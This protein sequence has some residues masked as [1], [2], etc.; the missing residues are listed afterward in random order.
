M[1]IFNSLIIHN[2]MQTDI[3]YKQVLGK[4]ADLKHT[5]ERFERHNPPSTIYTDE[6]HKALNETNKLVSAYV[7]LKEHKDVS[8]D[9][10]LH[11]KIMTAEKAEVSSVVQHTT[12]VEAP[13][14]TK[15]VIEEK[16]MEVVAPEQKTTE[17]VS[18]VKQHTSAIFNEEVVAPIAS[19]YPKFLVNIN[20]K[21][22]FINE[23]FAGNP[24]EYNMAMEQLNS[25]NSRIEASAYLGE[26]K[27]LYHWQD[28]N[29]MVKKI[30]DLVQKRFIK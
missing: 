24:T 6:L 19:N 4:L 10:N 11:L 12:K 16:Q 26:L 20:D 21:F 28:D 22:R 1:S 17:V 9:L 14:L 5:M 29:E 18:E 30:T 8:P 7:V 2:I 13:Q 23:L 27:K 3:L 15:P 25:V